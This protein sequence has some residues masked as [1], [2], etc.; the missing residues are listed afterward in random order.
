LAQ[1]QLFRRRPETG[2]RYAGGPIAVAL[3]QGAAQHYL[4]RATGIKDFDV[5]SFYEEHDKPFPYRRVAHVDF[6][7]PRFGRSPDRPDF[8]G[9][10]VDLI[11][12]SIRADNVSDPV[13]VLRSYLE[14]RKTK[15]ARLLAQ[16][17]V[18]IVEPAASIGTVAW[19]R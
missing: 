8:A 6:G 5:W 15:S 19:P 18:I 7:D 4:D 3:C 1:R 11:G 17:A 10:R 14:S 13:A 2:R 12:R 9:R 16:K